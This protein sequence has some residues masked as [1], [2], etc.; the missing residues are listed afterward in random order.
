MSKNHFSLIAAACI[1]LSVGHKTPGAEYLRF[2]T[3]DVEFRAVRASSLPYPYQ[4]VRFRFSLRNISKKRLGPFGEWE[5]F[6]GR[7]IE[8][9]KET[10]D[11]EGKVLFPKPQKAMVGTLRGGLQSGAPLFLE[12]GEETWVSFPI[13]VG[14]PKDR[15]KHP[16]NTG[17]VIFLVP[18][19]YVVKFKLFLDYRRKEQIEKQVEIQV[20]E[21]KG[22]DKAVL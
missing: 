12:P 11:S 15:T 14:F 17:K 20:R 6:V 7:A 18:G 2:D 9:P 5:S 21:P 8:A 22:D 10:D 3:K 13:A 4:A 1:L 19:K 16:L